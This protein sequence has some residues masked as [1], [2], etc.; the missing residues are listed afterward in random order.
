MSGAVI[1]IAVLAGAALWC[2]YLAVLAAIFGA[3]EKAR[4]AAAC[5]EMERRRRVL[6]RRRA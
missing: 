2:A 3:R 4:I 5:A 6:A 1:A